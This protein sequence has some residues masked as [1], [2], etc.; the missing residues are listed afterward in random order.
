[1]TERPERLERSDAELD[2]LLAR[3][4]SR[5]EPPPHLLDGVERRIESE[6]WTI[7]LRRGA[8]LALAAAVVVVIT[9]WIVFTGS[10]GPSE[11]T[12]VETQHAAQAPEGAGI[13]SPAGNDVEQ[14]AELVR[15]TEPIDTRIQFPEASNLFA[16]H[17]ESTS[18]DVSIFLIYRSAGTMVAESGVDIDPATPR[19]DDT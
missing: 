17:I 9:A 5:I 1:M 13:D 12:H 6:R 11:P 10:L 15:R 14:G 4:A 2:A 19:S 8:L 16:R 3:A 18:S 7:H